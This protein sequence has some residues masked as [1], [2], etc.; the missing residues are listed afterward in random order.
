MCKG[1]TIQMCL[2]IFGE[3]YVSYKI[4]MFG[5]IAGRENR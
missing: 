2:V 3:T 5:V 1:Y 4:D